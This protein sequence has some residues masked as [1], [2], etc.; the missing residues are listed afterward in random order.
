M[1]KVVSQKKK[2]WLDLLSAKTDHRGQREDVLKVKLKVTENT[3]DE[4][5]LLNEKNYMKK[6]W[7]NYYESDFARENRVADDD[8]TATEYMIDDGNESEVTVDEIIKAPKH[9]KVG[10]AAGYDRVHH[11][12]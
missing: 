11:L 9:M 7:K 5:H 3:D 6:R 2:A 10:K 4:G 8:V 12:N 1:R